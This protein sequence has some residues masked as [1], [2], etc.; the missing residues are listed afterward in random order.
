MRW[1]QERKVWGK[2]EKEEN[3]EKKEQ[4]SASN[5]VAADNIVVVGDSIWAVD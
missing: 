5:V 2:T 4:I 3:G 1:R